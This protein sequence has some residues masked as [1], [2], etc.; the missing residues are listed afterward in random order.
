VADYDQSACCL[1]HDWEYWKGGTRQDRAKADRAF[2]E[3]VKKTK[4]GWLAWSRWF[5]VRIGGLGV[6]PTPFRWGYGWKW[7]RTKAPENDRSDYN[8]PNQY[9]RYA[10]ALEAARERDWERRV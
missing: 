2:R 3:C 10:D 4:H 7:P 6:L 5:G 8:V 1:A 9:K